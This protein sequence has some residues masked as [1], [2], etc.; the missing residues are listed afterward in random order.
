MKNTNSMIKNNNKIIIK[1]KQKHLSQ[2]K[3][4]FCELKK[5]KKQLVVKI[6]IETGQVLTSGKE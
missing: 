1:E 6:I 4:D 3:P 2:F 5:K